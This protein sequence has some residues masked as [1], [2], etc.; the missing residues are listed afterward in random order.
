MTIA[1]EISMYYTRKYLTLLTGSDA[2]SAV[3]D[4]RFLDTTDNFV[5]SYAKQENRILCF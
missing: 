1:E 4:F 5:I 3:L 2:I